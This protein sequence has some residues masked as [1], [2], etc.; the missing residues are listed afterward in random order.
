MFVGALSLKE[1]QG[2]REREGRGETKRQ[3]MA[4]ERQENRMTEGK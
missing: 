2:K 3:S 4:S 1:R